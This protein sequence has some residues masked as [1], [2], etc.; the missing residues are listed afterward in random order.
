V[1]TF[2]LEGALEPGTTA[3]LPEAAAHHARVKR[4]GVG[5]AI[6]LGN[7]AGRLADGTIARVGRASVAVSVDTVQ[8]VAPPMP[9]ALYAPVG[10]RERMLW[11]AEK[12]TEL[13]ITEW[14]PVMF[15]RSRSV[16]PRG[17]G[18][19][20]AAKLRAR[21]ISALEQSGGGWLPTMFP[22]IDV[23][24]AAAV[25]GTHA[26]YLLDAGGGR[27]DPSPAA[28]GAAVILGPE[29]GM[30]SAEREMLIAGGWRPAALAAT[31]LRFETAGI[32]ALAIVRAAH[33]PL[34]EATDG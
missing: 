11:L 24:E 27:L 18:E 5:D 16:S 13:A 30:E 34:T 29:G 8:D 22:E 9:L 4:L 2:Y 31:I 21:M 14:H 19:A 33:I 12:A 17:E 10:D 3:E 26:R 25:Q 15:Q 28:G 1:S 23:R 7:G 32:A 20:F 6:R